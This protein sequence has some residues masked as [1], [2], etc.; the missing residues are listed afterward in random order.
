MNVKAMKFATDVNPE[1]ESMPASS[2]EACPVLPNHA[3]FA[4]SAPMGA[5]SLALTIVATIAVVFALQWAEKFFI[6]LL[7]GIIIAYTLNPLVVWMERV[8]IPRVMGTIDMML[9]VL[10]G[11]GFVT[12]SLDGQ[13]Q[14]ILDQLPDA[15][16]QL[17][18]SLRNM[19]GGAAHHHAE[20]ASRGA[21]D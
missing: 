14:T 10:P 17:S 1:P 7:L 12:I 19:R 16:S 3:Q 18:V 13:I 21:R 5:R 11:S 20:S 2:G 9:A 6:P 8:K 15:V 4:D